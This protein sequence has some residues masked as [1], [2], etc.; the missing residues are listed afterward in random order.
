MRAWP[1]SRSGAK[2]QRFEKSNQFGQRPNVVGQAG[3]HRGRDAERLM[4]AAEIVV[5]EMQ[6]DRRLVRLK[7]FREAFV[8]R[9]NRRM[10]I[11]I[12]RF[13]RST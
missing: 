11:R 2:F 4:D 9:V 6:R 8:R 12:V 10:L 7:L 5:H 3:V 1:R 13:W